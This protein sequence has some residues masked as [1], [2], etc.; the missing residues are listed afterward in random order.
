MIDSTTE[1]CFEED[2][3]A[4][5]VKAP[6]G[7]DALETELARLRIFTAAVT[8]WLS[9]AQGIA[10]YRL[11]RRN[12]RG[13][14]L[15]IGSFCG[16]STLFLALGCKHSGGNVITIDPHKPISDGGKEQYDPDFQPR[17]T[18]T[19]EEFTNNVQCSGLGDRIK[20]FV[21]TSED[22]K[23]AYGILAL[24]LLFIDGSHDFSDVLLDYSLWHDMIVPG[25][26]LVFHDSNF[27]GVSRVIHHHLDRS[28]YQLDG[29][30]ESG[31]WA[32]TLWLKL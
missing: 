13:D 12:L 31:R 23:K 3:P 28:R 8:G 25:G 22:A 14:V 7:D 18:R 21:G 9:E 6:I 32:M 26:Y 30:I 24:K 5:L 10:L 17:V 27:D 19:L 4:W 29:T 2:L 15:E 1:P 20:P 16:K 11:A